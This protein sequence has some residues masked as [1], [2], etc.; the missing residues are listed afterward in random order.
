MKK[1]NFTSYFDGTLKLLQSITF[2]YQ[3]AGTSNVR[4]PLKL[5]IN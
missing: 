5:A 3:G 2:Y 1:V 4:I